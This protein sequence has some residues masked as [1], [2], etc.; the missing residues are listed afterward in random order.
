MVAAVV[1]VVYVAGDCS[2]SPENRL[3]VD[4]DGILYLKKIYLYRTRLAFFFNNIFL[5]NLFPRFASSAPF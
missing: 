5:I 3:K 2:I 1:V 4:I